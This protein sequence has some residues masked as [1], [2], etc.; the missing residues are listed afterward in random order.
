MP[1]YKVINN[2]TLY[3]RGKII[4]TFCSRNSFINNFLVSHREN[5]FMFI[6]KDIQFKCRVDEFDR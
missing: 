1:K 6:Q 2:T 5:K 4:Y 3:A